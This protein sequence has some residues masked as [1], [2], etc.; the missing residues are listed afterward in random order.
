MPA[1]LTF[2]T[3]LTMSLTIRIV[4]YEGNVRISGQSNIQKT[5]NWFKKQAQGVLKCSFHHGFAQNVWSTLCQ[6]VQNRYSLLSTLLSSSSLSSWLSSS[7][8][9]SATLEISNFSAA[10]HNSTFQTEG[11]GERTCA[12]KLSAQVTQTQT[13]TRRKKC[14]RSLF[15]QKVLK[16]QYN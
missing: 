3:H 10:G 14:R 6:K 1:K 13:K 9:S 7:L 11:E 2:S 4:F 8:S 16:S 15:Y 5:A 12:E